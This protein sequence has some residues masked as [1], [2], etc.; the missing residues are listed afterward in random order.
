MGGDGPYRPDLY[1]G[2]SRR[3]AGKST[4]IPRNNF[5][6]G[7]LDGDAGS[8]EHTDVLPGWEAGGIFLE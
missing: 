1:N 5:Q 4:A 2:N 7:S 6:A 3:S 8:Y